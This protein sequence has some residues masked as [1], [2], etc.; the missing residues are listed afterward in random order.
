MLLISL[1]LVDCPQVMADPFRKGGTVVNLPA[2]RQQ[3]ADY[4][5]LVSLGAQEICAGIRHT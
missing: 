5:I 4:I 1:P 2:S 3:T